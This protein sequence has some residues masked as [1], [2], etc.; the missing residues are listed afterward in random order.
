MTSLF[1]RPVTLLDFVI[2]LLITGGIVGAGKLT[3]ILAGTRKPIQTEGYLHQIKKPT[4]TPDST[5][6]LNYF[7]S[8]YIVQAPAIW[9]ILMDPSI[10]WTSTPVI[11]FVMQFGLYIFWPILFFRYRKIN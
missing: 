1:P 3:S 10:S 9:L 7:K 11:L 4:W 8:L 2:L 5:K 6:I